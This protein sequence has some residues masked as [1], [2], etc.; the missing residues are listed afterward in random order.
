MPKFASHPKND[1]GQGFSLAKRRLHHMR[2]AKQQ[3][4]G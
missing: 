3:E 4:R 2:V 1:V